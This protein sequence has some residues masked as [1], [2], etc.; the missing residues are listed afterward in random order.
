MVRKNEI[1]QLPV[2]WIKPNPF[3]PRCFFERESINDLADSIRQFGVLQPVCVRSLNKESYEI[4]FGERRLKACKLA[5]LFYIPCIIA[6]ISDGDCAI[7]SLIE[8]IQSRPLDAFEIADGINNTLKDFALNTSQIA[9]F[10]GKKK[11]YIIN[12]LDML[13]LG[14][15]FRRFITDND[16]SDEYIMEFIKISDENVLEIVL[17]KVIDFDINLKKT[18]KIVELILNRMA[19]GDKLDENDIND[20]IAKTEKINIEQKVKVRFDNIKIFTNSIYQ[21][22]DMM[23]NSGVKT[24][25]EYID[26]DNNIVITL[27]V[28]K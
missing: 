23:N 10:L 19:F 1:I 11:S 18:K 22:V 4:V 7:I 24:E 27:K 5:G 15:K 20:I 3:Q 26:S 12:K 21:I 16:L 25:C 13:K 6:D 9:G 2:S 17:N 28:N 8:N 14:Y